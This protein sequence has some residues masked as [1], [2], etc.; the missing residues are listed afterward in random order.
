[1]ALKSDLFLLTSRGA[2]S[3][4]RALRCSDDTASFQFRNGASV[5]YRFSDQ[6]VLHKNI[7]TEIAYMGLD[8][9]NVD[10]VISNAGN[11]ENMPFWSLRKAAKGMLGSG[12]LILWLSTFYNGR[13]IY[14]GSQ[15]KTLADLGVVQFDLSM[16]MRTSLQPIR[17]LSCHVVESRQDDTHY[18]MPGP[19]DE[20]GILL[21]RIVW[22][23]FLQ[24]QKVSP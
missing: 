5:H 21:A 7:D 18:C 13:G 4:P 22:A 16:M 14:T 10:V 6:T 9:A 17:E 2:L 20:L 15:S 23:H 3:A 12:K 1:M 8:S 24:R 19:P 11:G